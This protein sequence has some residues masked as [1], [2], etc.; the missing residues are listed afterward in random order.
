MK[1]LFLTTL[2]LTIVSG[3][4]C[5]GGIIVI[6]D[7]TNNRVVG[8]QPG[9][10]SGEEPIFASAT[11]DRATATLHLGD[12]SDADIGLTKTFTR[13]NTLP[14]EW[15]N[16]LRVVGIP[17]SPGIVRTNH[18]WLGLD[19]AKFGGSGNTTSLP[20]SG[21]TLNLQQVDVTLTAY[22]RWYDNGNTHRIAEFDI[23]TYTLVPEPTYATLL[24]LSA[25]FSIAFSARKRNART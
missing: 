11:R 2:M 3:P 25:A 9:I 8:A 1:L 15:D 10:H 22:N 24:F 20:L 6:S 23:R 21:P 13:A 7:Q 12:Y 14:G 5:Y 17:F 4:R 19:T 18:L 16:F